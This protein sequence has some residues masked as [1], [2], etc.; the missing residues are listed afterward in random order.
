[1]TLSKSLKKSLNK[2]N[3]VIYTPKELAINCI[4]SF[5]FQFNDLVLDAFYGKGIFYDNYPNY[6]K[7]DFC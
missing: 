7:K 3:D 2:P 4:N 6:V 5:E 1:M